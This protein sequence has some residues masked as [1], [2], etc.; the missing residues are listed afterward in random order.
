MTR[1]HW[2]ESDAY[3]RSALA[4]LMA[5]SPSFQALEASGARLLPHFEGFVLD[6]FALLFKLNVVVYPEET[7][8]PSAAFYKLIIDELR[9]L[10]PISRTLRQRARQV[11][12]AVASLEASLGRTPSDRETAEH[13]GVEVEELQRHRSEANVSI[14]SLDAFCLTDDHDGD[15]GQLRELAD[16]NGLDPADVEEQQEELRKLAAAVRLLPEREQRLLALYYHQELSMKQIGRL[17]G[18]SESRVCQL[19]SRA[20]L[21][22][23]MLMGEVGAEEQV[24][25]LVRRRGRGYP[26]LFSTSP[27]L[28]A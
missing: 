15:G 4:R 23:R 24:L 5:D 14:V 21:A 16:E 17:L 25:S 19:H 1:T 20:I 27:R 13:L 2:I 18:I 22:L 3:D 11:G 26:A 7:V 9:A 6:L 8:S 12:Q 10:T 28:A